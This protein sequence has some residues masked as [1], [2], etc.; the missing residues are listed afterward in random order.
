[1]GGP[2]CLVID[3]PPQCAHFDEIWP[4]LRT[5]LQDFEQRY[6]RYRPDSLVSMINRRAGSKRFTA[7]DEETQALLDFADQL[8][9]TSEGLFDITS[10]P[11][12]RAWQFQGIGSAEPEHIASALELVG[13]HHVQREAASILLPL[14]GMEIDLGGLVKEYAVDSAIRLMRDAGVRSAMLELAGDVGVLG[15]QANGHPWQI[16]V[17][18]PFESG[19]ICTLNLADSSVATSGSYE[20]KLNFSGKDYGHLLDPR[21]GWPTEGPVSVSVIGQSC[22]IAGAIST[23]ACLH[24]EEKA[25]E[26]LEEANLPW[27]MV[28]RLGGTSGPIAS[29]LTQAT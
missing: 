19:S 3:T 11:L 7:V 17:R 15:S 27:L 16:G 18:D 25:I 10:G 22:L 20:R 24:E 1:M 26:W 28:N 13:W 29:D 12:R 4:A 5:L 8:W 14:E 23:V 2:A 21:S 9:R 6:S